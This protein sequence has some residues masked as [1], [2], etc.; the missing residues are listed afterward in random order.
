MDNDLPKEEGNTTLNNLNQTMNSVKDGTTTGGKDID[1]PIY[2]IVPSLYSY[3][4]STFVTIVV[5]IIYVLIIS[6]MTSYNTKFVPNYYMFIDFMFG[7]NTQQYNQDFQKY[8]NNTMMYSYAN[9]Q[10]ASPMFHKDSFVGNS[11]GAV[12]NFGAGGYSKDINGGK[13]DVPMSMVEEKEEYVVQSTPLGDFF[14]NILLGIQ[15][16]WNK[17]MLQSYVQGNKVKVTRVY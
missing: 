11:Q 13:K 15:T 4:W 8:I 14:T 6:Y 1:M 16:I 12:E 3:F 7:M 9:M 17:I 10:H 2:L 5:F